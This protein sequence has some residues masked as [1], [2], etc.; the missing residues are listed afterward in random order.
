MKA[1]NGQITNIYRNL[2][3]YLLIMSKECSKSKLS[4]PSLTKTYKSH[5]NSERSL[6]SRRIFNNHSNI[7]EKTS[8][9]NS[10]KF[11]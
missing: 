7:K 6:N 9:K 5:V 4:I 3:L 1:N 8:N 11:E 10:S 2:W